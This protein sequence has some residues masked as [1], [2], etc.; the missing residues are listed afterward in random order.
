MNFENVFKAIYTLFITSSFDGWGKI[1]IMAVNSNSPKKVKKKKKLSNYNKNN[2][3]FAKKKLKNKTKIKKKG[4]TKYNSQYSSYLYFGSFII[5]GVWFFLNLFIGV[6]FS[7]FILAQKK[8]QNMYL[9]ENQFRWT[10]MQ[11]YI[12]LVEPHKLSPPKSGLK[13]KLFDFFETKFFRLILMLILSLNFI[14]LAINGENTPKYLLKI[15]YYM[16]LSLCC[17]YI[18]ELV[19]KIH[20]FGISFFKNMQNKIIFSIPLCIIIYHLSITI[21]QEFY[22]KIF[23]NSADKVIQA[24]SLLRMAFL[25]RFL[26]QFKILKELFKTLS[27]SLHLLFNMSLLFLVMLFIFS[28]L[29]VF[30]FKDMTKGNNI[31]DY[32]NFSNL[33]YGMMTLFKCSTADNW[34]GIMI[35][36]SNITNCKYG[37]E[38]TDRRCNT[39]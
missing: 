29:G 18:L 34:S 36:L 6:L 25:I 19:L 30:F 24:L 27:F 9:T 13:K 15:E 12:L 22:K 7:N 32:V 1:L 33:F 28:V 21:F 4:P 16:E 3:Y 14:C 31:D 23:G 17:I 10:Q 38:I 2:N 37:N 39:G 26:Q 5:I 11:K 8:A 20:I 35:D